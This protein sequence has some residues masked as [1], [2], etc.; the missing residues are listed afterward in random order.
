MADGLNRW[1]G[2]GNLAAEGE[3]RVTQGGTAV[4]NFRIG[5]NESY[6]DRNNE[7]QERCEWV[8][9]TLWGRRGE[10]LAKILKKGDR[11]LVEGSLRTD[12]YED[13][14][15]GEKRY[16]TKIN[17]SNVILLGGGKKS[18]DAGEQRAPRGNGGSRGGA[19]GG[20]AK[21][22]PYGG[23]HGGADYDDAD[24]GFGGAGEDDPIPF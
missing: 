7:R 6:L 19:S 2:V 9:C 15:T 18:D 8:S 4:L 10:A 1:T 21:A 17:V 23:G 16:S 24:D 22:P 14:K 12:S 3:L 13:K 20:A 5:C 11:V